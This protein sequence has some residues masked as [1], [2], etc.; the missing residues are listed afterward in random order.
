[1]FCSIQ[2]KKP[3]ISK[4]FYLGTVGDQTCTYPPQTLMA[5]LAMKVW[6]CITSEYLESI[7]K[8]MPMQLI[9]VIAAGEGHVKY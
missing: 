1:M 6:N 2:Q 3:E 5:G 4:I 7:Y 9:A 8:S